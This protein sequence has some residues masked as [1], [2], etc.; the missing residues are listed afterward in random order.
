MAR[1]PFESRVQ[2]LVYNID[3]GFGLRLIQ[4]GLAVLAI[5]LLI[6]VYTATQFRGLDNAEAMDLAQLGRNL[7]LTRRFTTLNVR[8]S[9]LALMRERSGQA[10]IPLFTPEFAPVHPDLYHAP[11]YPTLLAGGFRL[12]RAAFRVGGDKGA[13]VFAPEQWVVVPINHLFVLLSGLVLLLL[14]RRLFGFR[15]ALLSVTAYFLS[16][17]VWKDSLSGTG[18]PV[19]TFFALLA[20][21]LAFRAVESRGAHTGWKAGVLPLLLSAVACGLAILTRYA[22]AALAPGLALFVGLQFGRRSWRWAALYALVA[23][24]TVSPWIVRNLRVSGRPLGLAT[25]TALYDS[26]ISEGNQLERS[27]KTPELGLGAKLGA[28]QVKWM[29]RFPGLA[30]RQ[31][32]LLGN[33]FLSV[34]FLAAL[35]YRFVRREVHVFRWCLMLSMALLLLLAPLF[36]ESTERLLNLFWPVVI[37]FGL[38]FFF[39]LLERLQFQ[40]RLLHI[41]VI[42]IVILLTAAPLIFAILPPR[43]GVPY[44]PYYPPFIR[45]VSGMLQPGEVMCTDMPEAVAWYGQRAAIHIPPSLDEFYLLNDYHQRISGLYFTTITRDRPYT[46]MLKTHSGYKTWFPILEGRIPGDFPL[47]HGFQLNNLDQLFL[48][49]YPRWVGRQ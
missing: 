21:Y 26:R 44:P 36:G 16:N 42:T 18:L 45:H 34:F 12:G 8:P 6:L 38:A 19:A 33:G 46:R 23:L 5:L 1:R 15:I 9:S 29:S 49:D 48:T 40:M 30:D 39:L 20:G 31:L 2:D 11:V 28:L 24:L 47:V 4:G 35:F 13:G 17:T 10:R 37:A 32:R 27:V 7:M 41:A 14:A 22:A 3:V 43:A 25:Q